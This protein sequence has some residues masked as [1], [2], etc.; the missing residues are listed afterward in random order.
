MYSRVAFLMLTVVVAT[1]SGQVFAQDAWYHSKTDSV[2]LWYA[3]DRVLIKFV[4]GMLVPGSFVFTYPEF[5][6]G[7]P[8]ERA[9]Y[10]FHYFHLMP[11]VNVPALIA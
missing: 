7:I 1:V 3:T 11:G 2:P 6:P 9:P 8:P 10:R 5:D 4:D